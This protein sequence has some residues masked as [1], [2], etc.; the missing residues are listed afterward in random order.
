MPHQSYFIS[1][2]SIVCDN[3]RN[4]SY[5]ADFNWT[6][7]NLSARIVWEDLREFTEWGG[8]RGY[9]E[10]IYSIPLPY[11]RTVCT[12]HTWQICVKLILEDFEWQKL[13]KLSRQSIPAFQC[14]LLLKAV[15]FLC[16]FAIVFERSYIILLNCSLNQYLLVYLPLIIICQY[17]WTFK[18]KN[19]GRL[20]L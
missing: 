4:S 13:H 7:S 16:G 5:A 11:S 2:F 9:Q 6:Q 3:A 19:T 8:C 18:Y 10:V 12:S 20:P 17:I 1:S 15:E 14:F